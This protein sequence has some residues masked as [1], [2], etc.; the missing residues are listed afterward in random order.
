MIP[1]TGGV[2]GSWGITF[3]LWNIQIV[4]VPLT[5]SIKGLKLM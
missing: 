4:T 2:F 5:L 3:V 1:S